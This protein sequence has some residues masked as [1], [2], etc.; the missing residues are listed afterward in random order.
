M[1]QQTLQ[2]RSE[3]EKLVGLDQSISPT[4]AVPSVTFN[5][6][7]FTNRYGRAERIAGKVVKEKYDAS[8]FHIHFLP[9]NA[10]AYVHTNEPELIFLSPEDFATLQF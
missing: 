9:N 1:S 7:G 6:K 8:V 5:A 4:I 10:G 3:R 2:S